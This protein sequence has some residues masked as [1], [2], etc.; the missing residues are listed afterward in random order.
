MSALRGKADAQLTCRVCRLLTQLDR[1]RETS[2]RRSSAEDTC[3]ACLI[4]RCTVPGICR[5]TRLSL[6]TR[7]SVGPFNSK[8]SAMRSEETAMKWNTPSLVEICI[9]LEIN[10]YLPAEF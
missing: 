10:G 7:S 6:W 3:L 9:G 8:A 1:W 2:V 5:K 4:R